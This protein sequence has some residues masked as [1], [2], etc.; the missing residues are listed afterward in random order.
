MPQGRGGGF[1][2]FDGVAGRDVLR[3]I[4]IIRKHIDD[5]DTLYLTLFDARG[6]ELRDKVRMFTG[7]EDT[8]VAKDFQPRPLW[9]P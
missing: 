5:K 8:R 3:T 4:P 2:F 7:I 6:Q 9:V 1:D